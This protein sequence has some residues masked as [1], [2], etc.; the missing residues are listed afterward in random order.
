MFEEVIFKSLK[1][2]KMVID[3]I[4]PV[5]MLF[6]AESFVAGQNPFAVILNGKIVSC[7]DFKT[8]LGCTAELITIRSMT[9]ADAHTGV[10]TLVD[11]M[12][13]G[14]LPEFKQIL[15]YIAETS[16]DIVQDIVCPYCLNDKGGIQKEKDKYYLV[17]MSC[18]ARGPGLSTPDACI[19]LNN[20]RRNILDSL[21]DSD[22]DKILDMEAVR[23]A[24]TPDPE[25]VSK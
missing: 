14:D 8:E 24:L 22:V 25:A 20:Q 12:R 15:K 10:I 23:A 9:M 4:V 19:A 18:G 13:A 6:D 17:C 2:V 3:A 5:V 21:T 11:R 16:E 1:C 7:T